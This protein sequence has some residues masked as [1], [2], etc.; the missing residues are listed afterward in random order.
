MQWID[1]S[2]SDELLDMPDEDDDIHDFIGGKKENGEV[3]HCHSSSIPL[4]DVDTSF[5]SFSP[6]WIFLFSLHLSPRSSAMFAPSHVSI[7]GKF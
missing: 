6:M 4:F 5:S 1:D 2:N 3:E 7:A